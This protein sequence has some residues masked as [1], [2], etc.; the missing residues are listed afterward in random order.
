MANNGELASFFRKNRV[1][2]GSSSKWRRKILEG[3]GCPCGVI[4][5]D[6]DEKQIRHDDPSILVTMIAHKK[7]DACLEH[8]TKVSPRC[9]FPEGYVYRTPQDISEAGENGQDEAMAEDSDAVLPS[10]HS[11]S[12]CSDQVVV[13]KGEIREK[14][15]NREEAEAFLRDYSGSSEPAHIIV[16]VV[17]VNT[18][19]KMR[20]EYVDKAMVW[21]RHMPDAAI[22]AILDDGMVMTSAGGLVVDD[23]IM[24]TYVDRIE[25]SRDCLM[26]LPMAVVSQLIKE[27]VEREGGSCSIGVRKCMRCTDRPA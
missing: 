21:F 5:P 14:P 18:Y 23:D 11:W 22:K 19:S 24:S 17:L 8:L 13:F 1:I 6:I 7:A 20:L 25:G 26:G 10:Y 15:A 3:Q 16:A 27:A 12:I 4:S 9:V 2:L